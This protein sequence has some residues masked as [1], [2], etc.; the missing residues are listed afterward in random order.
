MEHIKSLLEENAVTAYNMSNN[1]NRTE[2]QLVWEHRLAS[3]KRLNESYVAVAV[4]SAVN[5]VEA[6]TLDNM[7]KAVA[8]ECGAA[9]D[10]TNAELSYIGRLRD[11][12][13]EAGTI[14]PKGHDK[15]HVVPTVSAHTIW[16]PGED[17]A[18]G[19]EH[20]LH[21]EARVLDFL[22][23]EVTKEQIAFG[24]KMAIMGEMS[25]VIRE[26]MDDG[27][28]DNDM[29]TS[30]RIKTNKIGQM[31]W[32][33]V[34]GCVFFMGL[35]YKLHNAVE[36]AE[37]GTE[38]SF[39]SYVNFRRARLDAELRRIEDEQWEQGAYSMDEQNLVEDLE[40]KVEQYELI[41][42]YAERLFGLI[43]YWNVVEE[44]SYVEGT[45]F[46]KII[47]NKVPE[48]KSLA[49]K[50]EELETIYKV[51]DRHEAG[52]KNKVTSQSFYDSLKDVEDKAKDER[53]GLSYKMTD[54][55]VTG[56][57]QLN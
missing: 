20:A 45:E 30:K 16:V 29:L 6:D 22:R 12:A 56:A 11:M 7:F 39:Q 32:G 50:R 42:P 36:I 28:I 33:S 43:D 27:V 38:R 21:D 47:L 10:T 40:H 52:S 51:M 1:L 54:P 46:K 25:T 5:G 35:A 17:G 24:A 14:H 2:G 9:Q 26:A 31:K 41:A 19:T 3:G 48:Q 57:P 23:H 8:A 13:I 34:M 53:R 44:W 4:N 55:A 49:E 15:L 18:E 37:D